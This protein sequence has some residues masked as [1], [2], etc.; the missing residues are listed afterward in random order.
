MVF[1]H[2]AFRS[3]GCRGQDKAGTLV[4]REFESADMRPP[5]GDRGDVFGAALPNG[6]DSMEKKPQ[7]YHVSVVLCVLGV[8]ALLGAFKESFEAVCDRILGDE[9]PVT[10]S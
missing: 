3:S 6:G 10:D 8:V 9:T 1:R 2:I 4:A 5:S 7:M